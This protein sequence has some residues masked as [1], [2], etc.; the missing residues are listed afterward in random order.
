[1]P[2]TGKKELQEAVGRGDF[3]LYRVQNAEL[4]RKLYGK[5]HEAELEVI[6]GAKELG[7]R[8]V[9]MDEIAAIPTGANKA[10]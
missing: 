5:L 6:I 10:K 4:V 9:L 1:M 8:F 3:T 7:L 2:S